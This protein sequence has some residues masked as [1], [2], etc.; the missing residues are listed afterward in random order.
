MCVCV[1]VCV[2]VCMR[3]RII[4]NV[5]EREKESVCERGRETMYKKVCVRGVQG[6]REGEVKLAYRDLCIKYMCVKTLVL[7][8]HMCI[9]IL[10]FNIKRGQRL[11]YSF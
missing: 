2:C 3:K 11:Q 5:C 7:Y 9:I 8:V 1:C 4:R 10:G 6:A